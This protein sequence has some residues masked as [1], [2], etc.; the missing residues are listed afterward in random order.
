MEDFKIMFSA[1]L[2]FVITNLILAL[3]LLPL[4]NYVMPDVF[5]VQ[6]IGY[7]QAL[8]L[9]FISSILFRPAAVSKS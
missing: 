3:L 2:V 1:V 8:C 9:V 5:G 4:W 6:A 7:G